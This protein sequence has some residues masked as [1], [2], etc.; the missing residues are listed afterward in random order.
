MRS[1]LNAQTFYQSLSSSQSLCNLL[2]ASV[3]YC[4][5]DIPYKIIEFSSWSFS[6]FSTV[7][8]IK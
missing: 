3:L 2:R 1:L 8:D 7:F 4:S 5:V 6:S